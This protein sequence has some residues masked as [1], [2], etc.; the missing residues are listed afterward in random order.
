MPKLSIGD[1]IVN[2]MPSL[3]SRNFGVVEID[4]STYG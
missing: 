2:D 4:K 1:K 3:P